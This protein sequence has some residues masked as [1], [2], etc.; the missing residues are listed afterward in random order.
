MI[1]PEKIR[2]GLWA[3]PIVLLD[4]PLKWLNCYLIKGRPGNRNLLVDTGFNCPECRE[5]LL[6]GM[7]ALYLVPQET[8]VFLTHLHSDHSGNAAFLQELGCRLIMGSIDYRRLWFH[9]EGYWPHQKARALCEGVSGELLEQ[10][11]DHNPG[12]LYRPDRFSVEEVEDGSE[13]H[14]GDY[15]LRCLFTPGHTPGHMSLYEPEKKILF[16]GDH[17]LFDITPNICNW[18][19]IEDA[20]GTY[21]DSLRRLKSFEVEL[22]LPAHRNIG[23]ITLEE[24]VRQLLAHHGKRLQ[25][26]LDIVRTVGE[27]NAYSIAGKMSWRIQVQNWEDFPPG[28][29]WFA[30]GETLAHLDHLTARGLLRRQ[31]DSRG[32]VTYVPGESFLFAPEEDN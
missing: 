29:K 25:E 30:Y 19:G 9:G 4:N 26:T 10:L 7:E 15:R 1:T 27:T 22:A 17:V 28:Q 8:D 20:L 3:F 5:S 12:V 6:E 23:S 11:F 16:S 24:R 2:E 32:M 31:R 18:P 21:L 13:L 14:Y